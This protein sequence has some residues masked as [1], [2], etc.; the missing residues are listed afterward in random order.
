M[1]PLTGI[2]NNI[3][4]KERHKFG[5]GYHCFVPLTMKNEKLI[6]HFILFYRN[7]VLLIK[8]DEQNKI[9]HYKKLTICPALNDL[10]AYSFTIFLFL[11]RR[12][13]SKYERTKNVYNYSINDKTW[14]ELNEEKSYIIPF[15]KDRM[16][17]DEI[18]I[19]KEWKKMK[20][21]I[22]TLEKKLKE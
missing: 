14:N 21:Q 22:E 16:I 8:Y 5:I 6:N 20:T 18:E 4:L 13:N 1:K 3:I 2:K 15:E 19:A 11:F 9:F 17:E 12:T 10:A 7:T